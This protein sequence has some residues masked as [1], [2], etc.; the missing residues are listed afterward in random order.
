MIRLLTVAAWL[1]MMGV[2]AIPAVGFGEANDPKER[3]A[4]ARALPQAQVPLARGLS[5]SAREGVPLSAKFEIDDGVF[6]LSVYTM[7]GDDFS[8]VI[9]HYATGAVAK[10]TC[11]VEG[12]ERIVVDGQRYQAMKIDIGHKARGGSATPIGL[13]AWYLPEAKRLVKLTPH[14]S[15][16][17]TVQVIAFEVSG[18]GT[19]RRTPAPTT[20]RPAPGAP[21]PAPPPTPRQM[22]EDR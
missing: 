3:D 5:A 1:T 2:V 8:E 9:V 7:S 22:G 14:Y 18:V 15:G 12:W 17:P 11:Q 10:V 4:L 16:G 21:K 6:Q 19:P 20:A 13:S